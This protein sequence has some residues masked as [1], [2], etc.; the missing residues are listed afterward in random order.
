MSNMSKDALVLTPRAGQ[1][2]R[3]NFEIPSEC[4]VCHAHVAPVFIHAYALALGEPAEVAWRC[5]N[6]K[7]D[8]IFIASYRWTP[9]GN[10]HYYAVEGVAPFMP[11][12]REFSDEI[13]RISP[14]FVALFNE[15]LAAE[16]YGLSRVSGPGYRKALEFLIKDYLISL[17]PPDEEAIGGQALGQCI[18]NRVASSKVKTCAKRAAWLGNDETHY[19]RRWTEKDLSDLKI[20]LELAVHWIE[21]EVLTE[22]YL[23]DMP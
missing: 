11:Q 18:E 7:C 22:R 21:D 14:D 5:T 16:S 4:P 3:P 1:Q 12:G 23:A 9:D 15:A 8:R 10:S 6:D 2:Q 20:L 13:I 19:R 17:S